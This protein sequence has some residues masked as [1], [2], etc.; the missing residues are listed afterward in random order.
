MKDGKVVLVTQKNGSYSFPKGHLIDGEDYLEAAYREIHEETGLE[1]EELRLVR[2]LGEYERPDGVT[3]KE[4]VIHLFLFV[5]GKSELQPLDRDNPTA[6]W[7]D[8]FD[9]VGR[10]TYEKDREFFVRNF[11]G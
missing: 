5:T 3:G 7:I 1:R 4:K 11:F 9:V 6:E 8:M 10:L 2:D